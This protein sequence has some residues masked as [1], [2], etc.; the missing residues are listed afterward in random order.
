MKV[1]SLNISRILAL[2]VT[3]LCAHPNL[4]EA[5]KHI[6]VEFESQSAN[7]AGTIVMP[8]NQNIHA[9]VVFVHGSGKQTRNLYWAEQFANNGIAALVYDKRGVGKSGGEYESKQSVSGMNISLLADDAVAALNA[10]AMNVTNDV[11][12]GLTGISQAGWIVPMAVEKTDKADF[13]LLWSGPVC[14]VS[15]E[16]IFS[17]YT[18]DKDSEKNP[19]YATA[20][21]A[22]KAP[23]VWPD[24]LGTDS[25]P[26]TSL[27]NIDIPGL[28]IF[29]EKDGSIP[30]DLSIERLQL[31]NNNGKKFEYVLF[32][33][34][35]HN[36]MSSTWS[37]AMD[38]INS[39]E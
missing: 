3:L 15:E 1:T 33:H 25:D 10:L 23:Y 39:L 24:F 11:P 17:K 34:Q 6:A 13:M 19:S 29:G 5:N 16:D 4:A 32:S 28:W 20:L 2:V 37:T 7:L 30:V 35:G 14:R 26:S 21:A 12:L 18:R 9:A 8:V 38:W 36:N 31:L 22:R 27:A